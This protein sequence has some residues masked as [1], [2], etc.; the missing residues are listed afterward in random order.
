M[1]DLLKVDDKL[2]ALAASAAHS[3]YVDEEGVLPDPDHPEDLEPCGAEF[4]IPLMVPEGLESGDDR[5]LMPGSL[6]TRELPLPL[7]WQVS[8]GSGH[9]GSYLVGRIDSLEIT[10]KG[11]ENA[12]GVFDNGP[13]GREAERLVRNNMLRGVS[14]DLDKFRAATEKDIEKLMSEEEP[15]EDPDI[16]D[17]E[18]LD[19]EEEKLLVKKARVMAA[20]LLPKPA[21]Q[22]CTI[23]L[24]D[25]EEEEFEIVDGILE[26]VPEYEDS[27]LESAVSA[28]IASGIPV[29]PPKD[30][31]NNP[32][33]RTETPLTVEEDGRVFGHIATWEQDHIG[34]NYSQKPP[35]NRSG[36]KFFHTGVVR[37]DSG[38]DVP[39]GQLTLAG[40]HADLAFD[41]EMTVKHYDD[42]ASAIAD[43]HVGEDAYGIWCAGALRPGVTPEQVRV[44]RASSPSGDW[45]PFGNKLELVAVLQTNVPGFPVTRACVAS[46]QVYAL[47]AAGAAPLYR[48]KQA[49][50]NDLSNRVENL[51]K[52]RLAE[53]KM[54]IAGPLQKAK[55]ERN[56]ALVASVESLRARFSPEIQKR[57]EL[58]QRA[59]DLRTQFRAHFQ[60]PY[61]EAQHP[62]DREGKWRDVLAK[63][64]ELFKG[65]DDGGATKAVERAADAEAHGE[66]DAAK[67]AGRE[68]KVSLQEAVA[69]A[70]DDVNLKGKLQ[71]AIN[72]IDNEVGNNEERTD[73]PGPEGNAPKD[74]EGL[75]EEGL[76]KMVEQLL[77]EIFEEVD[78]ERLTDQAW[79]KLKAV[80]DGSKF[81]SPEELAHALAELLKKQL[82][83]NATQ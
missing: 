34:Y 51:E 20:T 63:L 25:P 38:E 52:A 7:L 43:I 31:F 18:D 6:S 83:P 77:D 1:P 73:N 37:T 39:V 40:G 79:Q 50:K 13:Y 9:D 12:R 69:R 19:E 10:D 71:D 4:I 42:T 72:L 53:R 76:R 44:C 82:Q 70:T 60:P 2:I 57:Q 74:E 11:I 22:E 24:Y 55:E 49:E 26:D 23:R 65:E 68:A 29:A 36:Y 78:P 61:I 81:S 15:D 75:F 48:L 45:R 47:V 80:A 62:R 66:N 5:E 33:L 28:L 17:I 14:A 16:K 27:D 8:T 32:K 59:N 46:G 35:R 56:L 3:A 67:E 21:F 58:A 64:S 54:E 30:W 41:P